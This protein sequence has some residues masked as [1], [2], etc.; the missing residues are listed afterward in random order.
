MPK[1]VLAWKEKRLKRKRL[2]IKEQGLRIRKVPK[3]S[4][5]NPKYNG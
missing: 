1:A 2:K 3:E 5:Q 4:R